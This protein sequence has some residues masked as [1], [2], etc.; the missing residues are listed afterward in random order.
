LTKTKVSYI[1]GNIEIMIRVDI[2][3]MRIKI[4]YMKVSLGTISFMG[5]EGYSIDQIIMNIKDNG[6]KTRKMDMDAKQQG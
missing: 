3:N 6:L 4:A 1:T 2:L 5:K